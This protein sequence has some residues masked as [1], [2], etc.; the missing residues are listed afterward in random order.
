MA[1]KK[2]DH[3]IFYID[4]Q[5]QSTEV[6][7]EALDN[8][9]D[10][11]IHIE[12]TLSAAYEYIEENSKRIVLV[13]LDVMMP[14]GDDPDLKKID[15]SGFSAGLL[16]VPKLRSLLSEACDIWLVSAKKEL[17]ADSELLVAGIDRKKLYGKPVRLKSLI[18]DVN[19]YLKNRI[20]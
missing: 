13:L 16:A 20:L 18:D 17:I 19:S 8:Y 2:S 15:P 5:P 12:S 11:I 1:D 7:R 4:D 3:L 10:C 6:V 9:T 14:V